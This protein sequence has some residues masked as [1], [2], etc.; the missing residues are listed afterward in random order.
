MN[1]K[2]LT[3]ILAISTTYLS[4]LA[5]AEEPFIGVGLVNHSYEQDPSGSANDVTAK[6]SS[7]KLTVGSRIAKNWVIEAYYLLPH[8]EDEISIGGAG[9]VMDVEYESIIGASLNYAFVH[10][11]S[12]AIYAGPN[13]SAAKIKAESGNAV[14]DAQNDFDVRVSPGLG[15]G[16]D[17]TLYKSLSLY[18]EGQSYLIDS[19]RLGVGTGAGFRYH[20]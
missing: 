14:L 5:F 18:I 17:I 13:V 19:G 1:K 8:E 6:P 12:F 7:I 3:L 2:T 9:T 10:T 15:L 11:G 20:L 16:M 4:G